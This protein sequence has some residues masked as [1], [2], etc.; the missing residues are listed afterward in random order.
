MA[1]PACVIGLKRPRTGQEL[2][3][4]TGFELLKLPNTVSP[5]RYGCVVLLVGVAITEDCGTVNSEVLARYF[6][7]VSTCNLQAS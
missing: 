3:L 4:A 6:G 1:T 2:Q 5:R 7:V